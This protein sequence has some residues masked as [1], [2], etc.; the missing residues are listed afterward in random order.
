MK[1]YYS[2]R[3]YDLKSGEPVEGLSVIWPEDSIMS[4]EGSPVETKTSPRGETSIDA[5]QGDPDIVSVLIGGTDVNGNE[6]PQKSFEVGKVITK[7]NYTDVYVEVEDGGQEPGDN[8][9]MPILPPRPNTN[10]DNHP[11]NDKDKDKKKKITAFVLIG[12]VVVAAV[13]AVILLW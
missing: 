7:D 13:V 8:S 9:G 10:P 4:L 1:M 6:Y 2:V 11:V 3:V 5:D 12:V